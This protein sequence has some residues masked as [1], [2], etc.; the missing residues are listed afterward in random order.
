MSSV[1]SWT[2]KNC[3]P[4]IDTPGVQLLP[5]NEC[6]YCGDL[7][8]DKD[9]LFPLVKNKKPTGYTN[10]AKNLVPSCGP[11][12]QSKG[13]KSFDVW[14]RSAA[15][16]SPTTRGKADVEARIEAI[17][18][19]IGINDPQ[20]LDFAHGEIGALMA[21]NEQLFDEVEKLLVEIQAN[22]EQIQKAAS[23]INQQL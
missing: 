5:E 9:H 6:A 14:I 1:R 11:C 13:N 19:F 15:K 10:C 17:N 18:E 12:N 8:T 7:A 16:L 4:V 2:F 23:V 21:K 20:P 3:I 22:A